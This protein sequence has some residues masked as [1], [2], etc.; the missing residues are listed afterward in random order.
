MKET[1]SFEML[2][3]KILE[4]YNN[5]ISDYKDSTGREFLTPFLELMDTQPD[6]VVEVFIDILKGEFSDNL[7]KFVLLLINR[8]IVNNQAAPLGEVKYNNLYKKVSTIA[9][10]KLINHLVNILKNSNE[11]PKFR[12]FILNQI[13]KDMA[14]RAKDK[15][16]MI[17]LLGQ[18]E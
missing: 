1:L 8:T 12:V 4:H 16:K 7:K 17:S 5:H 6:S 14:Y 9:I 13:F 10:K 18:N 11:N 2:K 15:N 3:Q